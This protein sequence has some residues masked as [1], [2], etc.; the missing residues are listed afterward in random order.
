M[1]ETAGR[2]GAAIG[3]LRQQIEGLVDADLILPEDGE[4]LLAALTR[5][6]HGLTAADFRTS[7]SDIHCIIERLQILMQTGVLEAAAGEPPV[8]LARGVL[9]SLHGHQEGAASALPLALSGA[10]ESARD[11]GRR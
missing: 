11:A 3:R 8:A 9:A 6:L 10:T 4:W 5:T 7:R 1:G 2:S